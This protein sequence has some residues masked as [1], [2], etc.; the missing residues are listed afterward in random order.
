MKFND[1]QKKWAMTGVL[2]AVLGF[3]ISPPKSVRGFSLTEMASTEDVKIDE[4][5]REDGVYEAKYSKF[6][7]NQTLVEYRKILTESGAEVN[8]DTC[9]E[10]M[11]L[12]KPFATRVDVL[13]MNLMKALSAVEPKVVAA[14]ASRGEARKRSVRG[15]KEEQ[16]VKETKRAP[17]E[18]EE[19]MDTEEESSAF[20]S[21][22]A[23]L[24]ETCKAKKKGMKQLECL[25]NGLS[26]LMEKTESE[27]IEDAAV[28]SFI[29]RKVLPLQADLVLKN[30]KA[31]YEYAL[32][33]GEEPAETTLS[34]LKPMEDIIASIPEDHAALQSALVKSTAAVKASELKF[35]SNLNA[36]AQNSEGIEKTEL[37][38]E[39][40]WRMN[41]SRTIDNDLQKMISQALYVS[42]GM[43]QANK[44]SSAL[45]GQLNQ[46]WVD[47]S[48]GRLGSS[49][50]F[51]IGD[52]V[53]TRVGTVNNRG[54]VT[55][56]Q[57]NTTGVIVP[58]TQFTQT[59]LMPIQVPTNNGAAA[60]PG[61]Q[62]MFAQPQQQVQFVNQQP[63]QQ[64][65]GQPQQFAPQQQFAVPQTQAGVVNMGTFRT[66]GVPATVGNGI[67]VVPRQ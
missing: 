39:S 65:V 1:T 36:R 18:E 53:Y 30:R 14:S 10:K 66:G 29:Q 49:E 48:N 45:Q 5:T 4:I 60:V 6:N 40:N 12:D 22:L 55:P 21:S 67:Q 26:R 43:S 50:T 3:N 52:G 56:T 62:Q 54:G 13:N 15:V 35:I 19:E 20:S 63:Q 33:G 38:N 59:N 8:C 46:V 57:I 2:L 23:S 37:L 25:S 27:E 58:N 61:Q 44:L 51:Q 34:I 41:S 7:D 31:Q 32:N 24:A 9:M 17:K 47:Y 64:F 42:D 28:K 16:A 11:V